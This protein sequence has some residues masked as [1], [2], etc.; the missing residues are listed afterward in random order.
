MAIIPLM[1]D[2]RNLLADI[3]AANG[4]IA[5]DKLVHPAGNKS[6]IASLS[7]LTRKGQVD[8]VTAADADV[9]T[10]QATADGKASVKAHDEKVEAWFKAAEGE[11]IPVTRDE[12]TYKDIADRCSAEK[13]AVRRLH[14]LA[15]EAGW[16]PPETEKTSKSAKGEPVAVAAS[17]SEDEDGETTDQPRKAVGE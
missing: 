11:G 2:Q 14:K 6:L 16:V 17:V 3:V 4:P 9:R 1:R 15:V 8:D 12:A 7:F 5:V 10:Y 13:P